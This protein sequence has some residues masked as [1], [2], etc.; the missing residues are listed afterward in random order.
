[1][2]SNKDPNTTQDDS[3]SSARATKSTDLI[4]DPNADETKSPD[5]SQK[6]NSGKS[7]KFWIGGPVLVLTVAMI[8]M[9]FVL[10]ENPA[11]D[12]STNILSINLSKLKHRFPNQN[13]KLWRVI[14]ANLQQPVSE[15]NPTK[16]GILLFASDQRGAQTSRCLAESI[17]TVVDDIMQCKH[18]SVDLRELTKLTDDD[19][20]KRLHEHIEEGF[21]GEAKGALLTGLQHLSGDVAMALKSYTNNENALFKK[22]VIIT[23]LE[24]LDTTEI[25]PS[26]W[27]QVVMPI[28]CG[29]WEKS[30][31]LSKAYA[32]GSR[33]A[34]NIVVINPVES[35]TL[36]KSNCY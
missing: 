27:D 34:T 23:T 32:L 17:L 25:E 29:L 20:Y 19:A 36:K 1:M 31:G 33:V 9:L 5:L 26:S 6:A 30:I 18:I 16:P 15:E 10:K 3:H 14:R 13:E 28:V 12:L 4:K 11:E 35:E 24:T 7:F 2:D 21:S 22:T 8:L